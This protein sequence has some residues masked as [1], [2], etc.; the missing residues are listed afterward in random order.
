MKALAYVAAILCFSFCIAQP[1]SADVTVKI[2]TT[3]PL[4]DSPATY[5]IKG[6]KMRTDTTLGGKELV[7]IIDAAAGQMIVLDPQIKEA[8]VY[9]LKKIA[10]EMSKTTAPQD[11][12]VSLTPTG[13]TKA[14]LGREC[15]GYEMTLSTTMT[16]GGPRPMK[17]T[18]GG[19]VWLAKDAPGTKEWGD[20]FRAAADSGLFFGPPNRGGA[21]ESR[22]QAL[23]Y[24]AFADAGGIPY[25]QQIQVSMEGMPTQAP[26]VTMTVTGVT[27]DPIPDEKFQ[28]PAG[29]AKKNQ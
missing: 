19:P 1:A 2:T 27:T 26:S 21:Q 7:T 24:K 29:Y 3:G 22:S 10:S 13:K 17:V 28:I 20:F 9:D 14:I 11:S 18:V 6:A 12:K 15:A 8:T 23:M 16:M 25:Q 4:G 5:Y